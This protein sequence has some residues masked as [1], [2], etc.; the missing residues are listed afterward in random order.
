MIEPSLNPSWMKSYAILV[1]SVRQMRRFSARIFGS[2]SRG[3]ASRMRVICS[4]S[5]ICIMSELRSF[6]NPFREPSS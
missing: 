4:V 5:V 3:N 6:C 1:L 2:F